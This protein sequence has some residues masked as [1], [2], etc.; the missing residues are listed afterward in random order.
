MWRIDSTTDGQHVGEVLYSIEEGN[1]LTFPDGDVIAIERLV[2]AEG[3]ASA[4]IFSA[5][6]VM[7][8][9]SV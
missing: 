2:I 5:N 7:Q 4:V 6:Y 1:V 8:L 3:G 9:S